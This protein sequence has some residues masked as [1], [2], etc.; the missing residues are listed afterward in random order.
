MVWLEF[1]LDV[2]QQVVLSAGVQKQ[3]RLVEQQDQRNIAFAL[4]REPR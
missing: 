3:A 2:A 4:L 1:L